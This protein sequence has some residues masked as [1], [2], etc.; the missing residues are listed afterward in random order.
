MQD[1]GILVGDDIA[2]ID[3]AGIDLINKTFG[4]DW[5]ASLRYR[6]PKEQIEFIE[7]LGLGNS[8]YKLEEIGNG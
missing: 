7:K 8:K 4:K 5:F 1:I 6:N 2:A 3:C